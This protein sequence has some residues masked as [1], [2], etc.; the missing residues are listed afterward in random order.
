M[1]L[2]ISTL[3]LGA[4]VHL[5]SHLRSPATPRTI[6]PVC[7]AAMS[8][9]RLYV[10]GIPFGM[11]E[12]EVCRLFDGVALPHEVKPVVEVALQTHGDGRPRGF[13][14]VELATSIQA[15]RAKTMLDGRAV[16]Y[17]GRMPTTLVV[18]AA[19]APTS[20][21][22]PAPP[23]AGR[24]LWVGNLSFTSRPSA[25]RDAFAAA[26]DVEPTSVWCKIAT[27]KNGRSL[28][29]GTVR[30]PDVESAARALGSMR[31]ATYE[32]R[33]LL[34]Q[35]DERTGPATLGGILGAEGLD[36]L[37]GNLPA[38]SA[39][40]AI[41]PEILSGIE[42]SMISDEMATRRQAEIQRQS[43]IHKRYLAAIAEMDRARQREV[44]MARARTAFRLHAERKRKFLRGKGGERSTDDPAATASAAEASTLRVM[45]SNLAFDARAARQR[46]QVLDTI[47]T[48]SVPVI[49]QRFG[50]SEEAS[51]NSTQN[52]TTA[53]WVAADRFGRSLGVGFVSA[54]SRAEA[55]ALVQ[56]LNGTAIDG[57]V[58]SAKFDEP[59]SARE[60]GAR[61][62]LPQWRPLWLAGKFASTGRPPE[63]AEDAFLYKKQRASFPKLSNS[64]GT[65]TID[66]STLK[67]APVADDEDASEVDVEDCD[68]DIA[69]C[70]EDDTELL[71]EGEEQDEGPKEPFK[72]SPESYGKSL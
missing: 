52:G 12:A 45:L 15:E 56:L 62:L 60:D 57:R 21:S 67:W 31:G 61:G 2:S 4:V 44:R 23:I 17:G 53:V 29:Y 48:S 28:G 7:T 63:G 65:Y 33:E 51:S 18:R 30:F 16:S 1:L 3:L 6:A 68:D 11:T 10:G 49:Q 35:Y 54:G 32:D 20:G 66:L 19:A 41:D 5:G 38:E 8:A 27:G 50:L 36:A 46:R 22:K 34:V 71:D 47:R 40:D 43:D 70:V 59:E 69:E 14:F 39:V 55:S 72:P 26:G 58:L 42:S 37:G 24:L 9:T 13:G 25:V 64:D